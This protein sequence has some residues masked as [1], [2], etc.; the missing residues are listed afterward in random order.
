MARRTPSSLRG[1]ASQNFRQHWQ[2]SEPGNQSAPIDD[3]W[4]SVDFICS[5]LFGNPLTAPALA[6]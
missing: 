1:S 4:P 3:G 5:L 2:D 6:P